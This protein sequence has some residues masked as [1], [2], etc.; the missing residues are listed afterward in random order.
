MLV[1][2]FLANAIFQVKKDMA[3]MSDNG[4]K[5]EEQGTVEARLER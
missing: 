3:E 4:E 2:N 5:R 1:G